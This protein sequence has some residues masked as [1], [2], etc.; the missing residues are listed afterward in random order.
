MPAFRLL[1]LHKTGKKAGGELYE[2]ASQVNVS[3]V[4]CHNVCID[5]DGTCIG[6]CGRD[7][8]A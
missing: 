8:S 1:Y 5:D 7:F 2:I 4:V 3:F 6:Y